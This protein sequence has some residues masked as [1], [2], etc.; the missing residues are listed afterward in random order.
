MATLATLL[1]T[2]GLDSKDFSK[3]L[4]TAANQAKD[5]GGNIAG[6]L[7]KAALG[8]AV[9]GVAGI[10]ATFVEAIGSA[11]EAQDVFA[12]TEAVVESTGQAAG[13]SAK[14]MGDLASSLSSAS[15]MSKF[16]DEAVLAGEN[17]LATFTEIK[18]PIFNDATQAITDMATALKTGPEDQAI[19]LGKALNDPVTGFTKLQKIGVTFT[20]SQIDAGTAMAK[21]GNIAG[22]QRIILGEL[23]KEFGGSAAAAAQT[24]SGKLATLKDKF[25]ELL[26]TAGT[27]FLPVLTTVLDTLNSPLVQSAISGLIDGLFNGISNAITFV[28]PYLQLFVGWLQTNIPVGIAFLSAQLTPIIAWLQGAIPQAIAFVNA[29]LDEFKGALIAVGIALAA[30]GIAAVVASILS[31]FNPIT[32]IIGA[33]ALLGAAWAGDWGGIREIVA[34]VWAYLQP[35]FAELVAWLKVNVPIAIEA[36]KQFITNT[37]IP[38]LQATWAFIQTSVIPILQ[39]VFAWLKVNVPIAIAATQQ[40]ITGTLIPALQNAWAFIDT[41]VIPIITDVVT[42]LKTNVPAAITT[43]SG[44]FNNTLLPAINA[45]WGFIDK[46]FIPIIDKLTNIA[47]GLLDIEI[48]HASD[49]WNK[50]LLPAF[51]AIHDFIDKYI[52]PVF[53][54]VN[55]QVTT[56]QTNTGNLILQALTPLGN[57]LKGALATAFDAAK[58][59]IDGLVGSFN[60]VIS[61]IGTV[62]DYVQHLI[63]KMKQVKTPDAL[64]QHSPSELEQSILD[65]GNAANF[66]T[67]QIPLLNS[68]LNTLSPI[69]TPLVNSVRNLPI[70]SG[71]GGSTIN[72][73]ID[74]RGA[75]K[76]AGDRIKDAFKQISNQLGDDVDLR[77]RLGAI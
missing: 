24:F 6:F 12:Q 69:A 76:G 72:A 4:S 36:T 38:A 47:L 35:I 77:I 22:A 58:G 31:L 66:A 25:G 71:K 49:L 52:M 33:I 15:G 60:D 9:A 26:E 13:L 30:M 65:V 48:Q 27:K 46:N 57:L 67:N 37:L 73:T 14:Q 74:A 51:T 10:G 43:V 55:G 70:N 63:D 34:S 56:L 50:V 54:S 45:I 61:V 64:A 41:K 40:F 53:N 39:E 19:A 62:L 23:N 59:Y 32:L 20:Q 17:L 18:G 28:I 29:H 44:F 5:L 75:D 21:A 2:L 8:T 11:S 68:A 7:G 3:G 1:V 42:W 16:G